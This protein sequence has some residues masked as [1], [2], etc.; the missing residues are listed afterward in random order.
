M[1]AF[2]KMDSSDRTWNQKLVASTLRR[3]SRQS[4]AGAGPARSPPPLLLLM[5]HSSRFVELPDVRDA[6]AGV[7]KSVS[8]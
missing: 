1:K 2:L 3:Q 5:S 8:K 4:T 7:P 6:K